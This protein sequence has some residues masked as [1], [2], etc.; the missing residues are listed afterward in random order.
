MKSHT[1]KITSVRWIIAKVIQ[2]EESYNFKANATAKDFMSV[3]GE[4]TPVTFSWKHIT[5]GLYRCL[6]RLVVNAV[7]NEAANIMQKAISDACN[8][9]TDYR[10]LAAHEV[11]GILSSKRV[12][13]SCSVFVGTIAQ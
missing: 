2:N 3:Y 8:D 13:C 1:T 9:V 11:Y 4:N 12:P 5:R 7:Y 10:L 6:N